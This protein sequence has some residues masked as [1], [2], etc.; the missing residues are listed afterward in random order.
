MCVCVGGGGGGGCL[1]LTLTPEDFFCGC[2]LGKSCMSM[3]VCGHVLHNITA[4]EF[5][6]AVLH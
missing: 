1:C 2:H 3:C 5:V 6:H 4:Q